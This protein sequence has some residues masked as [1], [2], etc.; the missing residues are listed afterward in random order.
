MWEQCVGWFCQVLVSQP[1]SEILRHRN[2]KNEPREEVE[3]ERV[4]GKL[5]FPNTPHPGFQSCYNSDEDQNVVEVS[6]KN[7]CME[8]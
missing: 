2:V 1:I 3:E 7:K 4:R 6:I 5:E 8:I